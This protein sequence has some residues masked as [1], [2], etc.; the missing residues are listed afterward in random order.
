M[1]LAVLV[2]QDVTWEKDKNGFKRVLVP[3]TPE[4]LKV[5]HDLVAGITGFTAERGDQLVIETLP[6]ETTLHAGATAASDAGSP[7]KPAPPVP[8]SPSRCRSNQKTHD[9][10]RRAAGGVLLLLVTRRRC[11]SRRERQEEDERPAAQGAVQLLPRRTLAGTRRDAGARP[12][13]R[14]K[15]ESQ[16]AERDAH[17]AARWKRRRSA[18]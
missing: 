10:R 9:D 15:C 8:G 2:D 14:C 13:W 17:A 1:S 5:I 7:G 4:K 18:R 16:L 11:C 6:F 3:P 12:A